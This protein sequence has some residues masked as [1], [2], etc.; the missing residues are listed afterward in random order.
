MDA[1][2]LS[3]AIGV[4]LPVGRRHLESWL[5]LPSLSLL[6][7]KTLIC[8]AA[9]VASGGLAA[10][11]AAGCLSS[12]SLFSSSPLSRL[13]LPLFSSADILTVVVSLSSWCRCP[14]V[15][16]LK[17]WFVQQLLVA[18]RRCCLSLRVKLRFS[19]LSLVRVIVIL[20]CCSRPWTAI[21]VAA[22]V[23]STSADR[24]S[25]RGSLPCGV[26]VPFPCRVW[27]MW[28][29]GGVEVAVCG[30]RELELRQAL[31]RLHRL[32][33]APLSSTAT[34]CSRWCLRINSS[35]WLIPQ[36]YMGLLELLVVVCD[37][38]GFRLWSTEVAACFPRIGDLTLSA[39]CSQVVHYLYERI[40][41]G[42]QNYR[43]PLSV[44]LGSSFCGKL[45]V[46]I[47]RPPGLR[48]W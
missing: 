16:V 47:S 19:D 27:W 15:R 38:I 26:S 40:H 2:S 20:G 10:L 44:E 41:R 23:A 18:K 12:F 6:S 33:A 42:G 36:H 14:V 30:V 37:A 9:L 32:G 4:V 48:L 17:Q 46:R 11:A 13:L 45:L 29:V 43:V 8:C 24:V 31:V 1:Y 28:R 21:P 7:N 22:S 3:A 35:V 25:F 34:P 39:S 5:S